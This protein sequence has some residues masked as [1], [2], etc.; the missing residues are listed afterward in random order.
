MKCRLRYVKQTERLNSVSFS[1]SDSNFARWYFAYSLK[2][3]NTQVVSF[4]HLIKSE[5][6]TKNVHTKWSDTKGL[7]NIGKLTTRVTLYSAFSRK[8][9]RN[10]DVNDKSLFLT[11]EKIPFIQIYFTL[12]EQFSSVYLTQRNVF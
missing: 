12:F 5:I 4:I 9:I 2:V 7:D 1:S 11:T 3:I 10:E 8:R 6:Y